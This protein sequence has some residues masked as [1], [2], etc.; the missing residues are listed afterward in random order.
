MRSAAAVFSESIAKISEQTSHSVTRF[1]E[2][3]ESVAMASHVEHFDTHIAGL[4]TGMKAFAAEVSQYGRLATD[5]ALRTTKQALDASSKWHV[6][7][8][9][10][11]AQASQETM[12]AALAALKEVDLSVDTSTVKTDLQALSR[13]ITTFT[14][15]FDE[16]DEKL[17]ATHA[18]DSAV[19]L[20]PIVTQFAD[21]L[22]RATGEV[23]VRA[24][25]Q[26][27]DA[28]SR[29]TGEVTKSIAAIGERA[30]LQ[31]RQQADTLSS[32]IDRLIVALD[33]AAL[34]VE[35]IERAPVQSIVDAGIQITP[36]LNGAYAPRANAA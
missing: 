1:G 26:F 7:G 15:K 28:S 27:H 9:N 23:E 33:R 5:E 13:T 3:V 14:R 11:M 12:R 30:Q 24:L 6:D 18:R 29:I 25:A 22:V 2:V 8:L 19:A 10:T 20:E 34:R 16:L 32:Q 17:A 36:S 35:R 31:T 21:H 4:S